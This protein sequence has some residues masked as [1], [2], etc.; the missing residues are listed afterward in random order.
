MHCL[1][2]KLFKLVELVVYGKEIGSG[3]E[4]FFTVGCKHTLNV[5]EL[6]LHFQEVI[7]HLFR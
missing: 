7:N 4:N 1:I 3:T 6:G 2:P 5:V